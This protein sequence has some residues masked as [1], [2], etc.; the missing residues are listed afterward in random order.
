[1]TTDGKRTLVTVATY[2]ER[3]NIHA[4]L[5]AILTQLPAANVLV[6]DDRS[7]D[8]T[9][10]LV[11]EYTARD[12]RVFALHRAGKLGL[13]TAIMDAMRWG[14]DRDYEFIINMDADF[15]H[16]PA[17]LPALLAGMADH[18]VMIGSRYVEGGGV[19]NW[20]P[21]RKLMSW[22]INTYA[23]LL[24]GLK[25]RDT[26][27]AFRCYRVARL[28][29]IDF[30]EVRSR[31]YSFQEEFL[32]H[33]K[34][35]GCRIGETPIIFEDRRLGKSKINNKEVVAALWILGATG[36]RRSRFSKSGV[37]AG[38]EGPQ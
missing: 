2:N 26:S 38:P 29:E 13:G 31:G 15:S 14:M 32:Y 19:V 11:D 37:K 16:S 20:S 21:K 17:Y 7:P 10:A 33:C 25:A 24:L 9:G 8:G 28:R 36:A 12:P 4:L 3:E 23:R 30:R 1:M 34:R 18:D 6:V 35:V 5:D 22:A 27:G